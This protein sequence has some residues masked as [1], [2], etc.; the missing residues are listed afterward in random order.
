MPVKI[1]AGGILEGAANTALGGLF[2][3]AFGGIQDRRQVRQQRKLQELQIAGQKEMMDYGMAQQLEMWEKTN[4]GAQV[5]QLEKAGLNPG[6]IYGMGGGGGTTTGSAQGNVTGATATQAGGG[7]LAMGLQLGMMKAQMD[8]VKAQTEKTKVEA[9]KTAGVDTKLAETNIASI[10]QGINNQKAVEELTKVTTNIEK[11]NLDYN[12]A[13]FADRMD[14]VAQQARQMTGLASQALT[15]ANLD[16]DARETRLKIIRTEYIQKMLENGLIT[17]QTKGQYQNIEESKQR[18]RESE[19]RIKNLA[20]QI[21]VDW[22]RIDQTNREL[23]IK[24][25]FADYGTDPSNEII[26]GLSHGIGGILSGVGSVI[27]RGRETYTP[28]F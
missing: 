5:E 3:L 19:Q 24:Q 23:I 21:Q 10:T 26:R 1:N 25:M 16:T 20:N 6:L 7:E 15:Q 12:Q 11:L 14:Y 18:I 9:E 22:Y 2:G 17:A 28:P 8:L 4:Y 13:T 27:E